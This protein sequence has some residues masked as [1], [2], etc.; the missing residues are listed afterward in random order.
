MKDIELKDTLQTRRKE[1]GMSLRDIQSLTGLGYN[2]VRRVFADPFKCGLNSVIAVVRS[3]GCEL[4]FAVENGIG[5]ELEP[6]G[7]EGESNG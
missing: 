7:E 2:T 1:L 6:D 3:M 4:I 5:D